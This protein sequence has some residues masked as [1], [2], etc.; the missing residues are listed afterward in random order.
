LGVTGDCR[1]QDG[2]GLAQRTLGRIAQV[3][4]ALAEAETCCMEA[5]QTF[6]SVQGH[7]E[8]GRTHLA[9]AELAHAR[10]NRDAA[11]AHA[12]NAYTLFMGLKACRYVEQTQQF[13]SEDGL[14]LSNADPLSP[15]QEP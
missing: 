15:G 6:A 8:V 13:A 5:L 11:T 9:L 2:I 14:V 7:F 10:G 3:S 1:F 12:N 4:G